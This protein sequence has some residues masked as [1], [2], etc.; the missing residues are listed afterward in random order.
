[1][2]SW[3]FWVLAAA[4]VA[5]FVYSRIVG[6]GASKEAHALVAAGARIVDV[7]SPGEF[8]GGHLDGALNIPV[9]QIARRAAEIGAKD[10][11]VVLYC[12]SGA[13]SAAAASTLRAQGFTKIVNLGAMSNW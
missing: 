3:M 6:A 10:T 11:P 7:R 1:M 12:R 4:V 5:F 8:S 9:D 2:S 13:R